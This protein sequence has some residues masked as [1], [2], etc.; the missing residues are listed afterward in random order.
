MYRALG[1]LSP[2]CNTAVRMHAASAHIRRGGALPGGSPARRGMGMRGFAFQTIE[3]T[4]GG[5][6]EI[7]MEARRG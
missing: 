3:H 5:G 1:D 4:R 6:E 7:V 2:V